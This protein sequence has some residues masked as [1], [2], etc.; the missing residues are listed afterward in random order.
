[1]VRTSQKNKHIGEWLGLTPFLLFCLAFEFVPILLLLRDSLF[2]KAGVLTSVNYQQ[3]LAPLYI[4][5]F[6]NSIKLSGLTAMIGTIFGLLVGY[7]IYRWPSKR[8]QEILVTLSDVTTNFAGAPLAFAFIII[9][10]SNG[11]VTQFF[12]KSLNIAIYPAFSIYSFSGLILAYVYFQLPLMV[13]LIIPAFGGI[14]KEWKESAT[15]LGAGS[16]QF[17]WNIGL[18]ILMPSLIA[19]FVLLFAN[20]F[21]AYA[22]AYTLTGSR[23]SL[24][25]LQIGFT[26]TG[27]VLHDPGIGQA[28]AI[29]SLI[30]MGTCIGIYR[31][32]TSRAQRWSKR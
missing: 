31:A 24:V 13:L 11:L 29:I 12:L 5:S 3:A 15:N 9:L 17:W 8:V 28:M 30:I 32:A 20:A 2:T 19:G 7:N 1:M 14:K 27:E 18:P 21:G 6:W 4:R 22:T 25:T 16:L 23:L 10:G 26:I